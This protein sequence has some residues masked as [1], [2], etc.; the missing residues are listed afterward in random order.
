MYLIYLEN[1]EPHSNTAHSNVCV[2]NVC[3]HMDVHMNGVHAYRA[4]DNFSG[5]SPQVPSALCLRQGLSLAWKCR[6]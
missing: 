1:V 6:L 4:E 2:S 3:A 5:L